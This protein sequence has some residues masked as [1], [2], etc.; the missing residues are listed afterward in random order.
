MASNGDGG[1][2]RDARGWEPPR[3]AGNDGAKKKR[4]EKEKDAGAGGGTRYFR[5]PF[6]VLPDSPLSHRQFPLRRIASFPK[7]PD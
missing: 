3:S 1:K 4:D 2:G 6:V 5:F 7:T